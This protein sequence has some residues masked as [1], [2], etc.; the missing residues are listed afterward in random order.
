MANNDLLTFAYGSFWLGLFVSS[1]LTLA[2]GGATLL[3]YDKGMASYEAL[4]DTFSIKAESATA[5]N[6]LTNMI[7]SEENP[8]AF[9]IV[10]GIINVGLY[11]FKIIDFLITVL[12]N[13]F[14][15]S[16]WLTQSGAPAVVVA[17]IVFSWQF[18]TLWYIA[19]FI[20][21]RERVGN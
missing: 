19:T 14:L 8:L 12:V 7:N 20:F 17:L 4:A 3:N 1:I 15:L 10:L 13:Y 21:K 11:L 18:W 2:I 5:D 6:L 9:D 16:F